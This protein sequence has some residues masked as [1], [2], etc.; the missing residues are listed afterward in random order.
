MPALTLQPLLEN[1]IGHGIENLPEGGEV[2]IAG[3]ADGN[4]LEI[5]VRNPLPPPGQQLRTGGE[6]GGLGIAL[7]NI[8]ERLHLLYGDSASITAGRDGDQFIVQL[9]LPVAPPT[10]QPSA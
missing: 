4:M 8:R 6:R 5:S 10:T 2:T 3:T 1:A 9:R 7:E